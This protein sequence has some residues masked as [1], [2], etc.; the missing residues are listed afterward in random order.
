[1]ECHFLLFAV[2]LLLGSTVANTTTTDLGVVKLD[3]DTFASSVQNGHHF[4]MYEIF[5]LF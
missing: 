1:M 2:S 3:G 4:V 5:Y